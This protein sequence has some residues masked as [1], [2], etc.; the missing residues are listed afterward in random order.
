MASRKLRLMTDDAKWYTR[1]G[2]EFAGHESTQHAK[3]EYV[4]GDAHT[5][6]VEDYF[7]ILKRGIIGAYHHVSP[8]HLPRYLAEFDFSYSNRAK[9]GVTDGERMARAITG[10]RGK[11]LTYR[12]PD[13]QTT[14]V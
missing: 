4:R 11:R 8:E 14:A 5:N 12:N 2:E 13:R 3:G 7:S 9:L 10:A 6:T 1:I